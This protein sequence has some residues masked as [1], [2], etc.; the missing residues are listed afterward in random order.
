MYRL[1]SVLIYNTNRCVYLWSIILI[2]V[3]Y[4]ASL[5]PTYFPNP[6]PLCIVLLLFCLSFFSP[7]LS[8]YSSFLNLTLFIFIINVFNHKVSQ[9]FFFL[10]WFLDCVL[11]LA[12]PAQ[13]A[14]YRPTCSS[15]IYNLAMRPWAIVCYIPNLHNSSS[16]TTVLPCNWY[17][18][19]FLF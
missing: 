13:F 6:S 3:T 1:I 5:C 17:P 4:V 12:G 7:S 10:N 9:L 2:K 18:V 8:F 19:S 16:K 15:L 11:F 14:W